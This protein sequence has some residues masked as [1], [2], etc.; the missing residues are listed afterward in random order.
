MKKVLFIAAVALCAMGCC[1]KADNKC[2][3]QKCEE[4]TEVGAEEAPAEEVVEAPAV[5]EAPAAEPAVAEQTEPAVKVEAS[6]DGA[7]VKV[8]NKAEISVQPKETKG[9]NF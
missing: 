1:K 8:G 6:E 5:E 3:E 7:K 9:N 2:C 4:A